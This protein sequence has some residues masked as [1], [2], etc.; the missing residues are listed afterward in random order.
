MN[1]DRVL[2]QDGLRLQSDRALEDARLLGLVLDREKGLLTL[3]N[4]EVLG[5]NHQHGAV[6]VGEFDGAG[7]L[8]VVF[9]GDFFDVL[10]AD[11]E[12]AH[13]DEGLEEDLALHLVDPDGQVNGDA[14]LANDLDDLSLVFEFFAL[15]FD[16]GG[17]GEAGGDFGLHG[18]DDFE[19]GVEGLSEADALGPV[20]EVPD[21]DGYFVV[22]I[23]FDV[24][25]DDLGRDDLEALGVDGVGFG[26]P[27]QR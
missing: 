5:L 4:F 24:L 9:Y 11:L 19:V 18:V 22:L 7:G 8:P 15:V 25:E 13:I 2:H 20:G 12:E 1:V 10:F 23:D 17:G 6:I 16:L 21:F 3:V 27:L 14:V 26:V